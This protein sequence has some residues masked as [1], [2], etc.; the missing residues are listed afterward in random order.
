MPENADKR[1]FEVRTSQAGEQRV[2]E[3]HTA[4]DGFLVG[5][6]I[7]VKAFDSARQAEHFLVLEFVDAE[8]NYKVEIGRKDSRWAMDFLKRILDPNF[9]PNQ[10][11]R[12]APYSM[13]DGDRYNIGISCMSGMDGKLSAKYTDDH[14]K[15][16]PQAKSVELR[17]K[18]EWDFTPVAE[19]LWQQVQARV[20]PR[21]F[22]D[23]LAVGPAGEPQPKPN[24]VT[25]PAAIKA[26]LT[27]DFPN[28]EPVD[29]D[30][31][32]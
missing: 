29:D 9:N 32:F 17:G 23:P 1:D 25:Q 27:Q 6:D 15:G 7:E 18:T 22:R 5:I 20:V 4:L 24:P 8:E 28:A 19:W 12:I 30:L 16:M 3:L 31:P 10:K 26:T 21:L 14:L 2:Y 11:L 13:Q